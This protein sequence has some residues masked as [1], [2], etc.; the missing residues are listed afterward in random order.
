MRLSEDQAEHPDQRTR[1]CGGAGSQPGPPLLSHQPLH[2]IGLIV[3]S[4][5]GAG[6]QPGPPPLSHQPL[7][8][9]GLIYKQLLFNVFH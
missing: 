2:Q 4:C 6:S 5:G 7:H 1:S 9:I 8:Q 3:S